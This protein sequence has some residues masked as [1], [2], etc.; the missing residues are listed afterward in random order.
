MKITDTCI[1][2]LISRVKLECGLV[3]ADADL[4]KQTEEAC[5][6]LLMNLRDAPLS[7]PQI[8][9][10]VH[11]HAYTLIG[12]ADPFD[13]LKEKGNAESIAICRQVRGSLTTFRD[14]VL[15]AII[16]NTF[17]YGVKGHT[18]TDNFSKFFKQEF[19]KGLTIDDT[20]RILPLL[21]RVV[22]L[23]DNCGEIIFDR[24]LIQ[25]LKDQGSHVTLGVKGTPMLNDAT[26]ADAKML[27]LD[28][29]VDLLTVN[30]D[31]AE[32]GI[33]MENIPPDLKD[34]LDNCT[35]IIAKGMA[36][37]ESLSILHNLPPVAYLMA[38]KCKPVADEVGVPVG[39]K[40]AWLRMQ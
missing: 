35:L 7:H 3:H 18:V 25:Y 17:D 6:D 8:A 29:I 30:S 5:R 20:D 34:A 4:T 32:I 31:L 13:T 26:L 16:G 9:S 21:S 12:N 22:Y 28:R 1:D 27:G 39:S 10:R 23:S 24:L 14:F 15:A 19:D 37:Y 40:I 36:N 33:C 2:C 38:T 11:G